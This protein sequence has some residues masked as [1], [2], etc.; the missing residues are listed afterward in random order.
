M[1]PASL[2]VGE[3]HDTHRTIAGRPLLLGGVLIDDAP[4]GLDGHSDADVLIH[5]VIDAL[6]GAAGLGDI[7]EW[8]PDSSAAY[9][10]ADSAQLLQAV[11]K[12]LRQNHW[13]IINLDCTIHAERPR[14]SPWKPRIRQRLAQLLQISPDLVNVKAK[15][16]EQVGP[17]G[18]CESLAA[19][20]AVLITR[21]QPPTESSPASHI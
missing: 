17:V 16:G 8:F 6:L 9:I 21:T 11:V 13:E 4:F 7:G 2:R 14:L 1:H 12:T 15:S 19:N 5:A 18:R 20:A 3:G 10:N